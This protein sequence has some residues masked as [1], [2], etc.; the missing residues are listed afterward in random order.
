MKQV[1]NKKILFSGIVLFGAYFFLAIDD[2]I[3]DVNDNVPKIH[4]FANVAFL[5]AA[6]FAL[7]FF[8]RLSY[9]EIKAEIDRRSRFTNQVIEHSEELAIQVESLKSGV[10]QTI[11]NHFTIWRFSDAEKEIGFLLLK[12]FSFKEI[13][14]FR[15]TSEKTVRDQATNI[16]KKSDTK[17]RAEF[18][19]YFLEDLLG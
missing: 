4:I 19:A 3:D 17:N 12:G 2:I 6:V 9:K 7:I 13:G 1:F 14:N 10:T 15:S 5:A 18:V 16:Y 8:I 11:N